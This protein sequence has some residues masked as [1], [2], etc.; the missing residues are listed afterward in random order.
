MSSERAMTWP[1]R[2]GRHV[3]EARDHAGQLARAIVTVR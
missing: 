1:L 2:P 3:F